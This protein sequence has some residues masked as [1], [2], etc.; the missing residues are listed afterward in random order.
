MIRGMNA[1]VVHCDVLSRKSK[2]C[3]FVQNERD[4]HLQFSSL[5]VMP[6]SQATADFLRV[7]WDDV[8]L[9]EPLV[10][11]KEFPRHLGII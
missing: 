1:I 10:E 3:F 8:V 9:Y 2:G 4:D 11:S 5:N 7:E 6:Y